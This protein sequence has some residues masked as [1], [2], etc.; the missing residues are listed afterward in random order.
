[1]KLTLDQFVNWLERYFQAW[2]SNNPDAV[3]PLFS[4]DAVYYYGPFAT[5]AVGRQ[6]IVGRWVADPEEQEQV[7]YAFKPLALKDNLGIAHFHVLYRSRNRSAI[8]EMDGVLVLQFDAKLRC[9]D[10]REWY[11]QREVNGT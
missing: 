7:K 1:M 11:S 3:A 6:Q 4:D 10:H 8:L 2:Q 5:P 9:I